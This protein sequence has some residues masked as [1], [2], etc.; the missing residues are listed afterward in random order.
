MVLKIC[1]EICR[2]MP[3]VLLSARFKS[4]GRDYNYCAFCEVSF[5]DE[6]GYYFVDSRGR[7]LCPCCKTVLRGLRRNP[8]RKE[9]REKKRMLTETKFNFLR[10]DPDRY[11]QE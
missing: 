8:Y 3:E 2:V 5:P 1:Y 10:V 4:N 9:E 11:L 6:V 7:K